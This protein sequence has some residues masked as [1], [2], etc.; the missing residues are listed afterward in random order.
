MKDLGEL[1]FWL[2]I[3]AEY[4][5]DT[6]KLHQTQYV[7]QTLRRYNMADCKPAT[8]PMAV[9]VKLVKDDGSKL[10][11]QSLYQSIV[12]SL[13]HAAT[14]T[15]PDI[16]HAVGV[17]S[18]FSNKP[19]EMH[20]TAAKHVLRYLKATPDYGIQYKRNNKPLVAFSDASWAE[21]ED[22]QSTT[23]LVFMHCD[24]PISWISKQQN[25][26]ALLTAEAEYISA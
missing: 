24:G 5:G 1:K 15:R 20:L 26:V 21:S 6:L 11:D 3:Q 16:S 2:G 4:T 23:G 18:K 19:H 14:A 22:R 17:L 12:G 9:D 8:T 25:I 7:Q 10:T 13:L